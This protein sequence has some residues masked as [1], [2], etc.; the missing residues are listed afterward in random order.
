[1]RILGSA[2]DGATEFS[3]ADR[4]LQSTAGRAGWFPEFTPVNFV[5]LRFIYQLLEHFVQLDICCHVGGSFPTFLAGLQTT[6]NRVTVFIALKDN[7][8][9]HLIFKKGDTLRE[10]FYIG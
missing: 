7:P 2:F 10:I 6:F 8:L 4:R 3:L 1:M 9:L 5:A